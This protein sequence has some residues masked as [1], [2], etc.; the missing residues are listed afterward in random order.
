MKNNIFKLII[1][2]LVFISFADLSDQL[3][4]KNEKKSG[5]PKILLIGDSI[6]MGYTPTVSKLLK[7]KAE[8]SRIK[9]NGKHSTY[10]LQNIRKWI[11]DTKW[12]VIH[13]NWG[14]WDLCYRR[15]IT[16]NK[17][18]KKKVKTVKDKVNG[19]LTLTI[20]EYKNNIS[21]IVKILKETDAQLIWCTTTPVPGNEPGRIKGDAIKYNQSVVD[22]MKKNNIKINDLHAYALLKFSEIQVREGDVHYNKKGYVYLGEKVAKEILNAF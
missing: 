21:Q 20:E 7:G 5:T 14:L 13:F 15:E 16:N 6:S 8:V 3:F 11:G 10:G 2:L 17:N 19:K 12:D 1:L 18:K 4:S 9:G 22:I